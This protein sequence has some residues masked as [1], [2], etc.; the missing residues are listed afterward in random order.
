M[1]TPN[2]QNSN[3]RSNVRTARSHRQS[4]AMRRLTAAL[5]TIA[6]AVAATGAAYTATAALDGIRATIVAA[7]PLADKP[8][9]SAANG[10]SYFAEQYSSYFLAAGLRHGNVNFS[11]ASMW[12]ALAIAAQGA[13]GETRAQLDRVLQTQSL[14][15]GDYR[16]LISSINGRREGAAS[17]MLARNAVWADDTLTLS[18][19]FASTVR[20]AFD[21]NVVSLP[22]GDDATQRLREWIKEGTRGELAPDVRLDDGRLLS[23]VNTVYA[24]GRWAEPFDAN[25][26]KNGTFHGSNSDATVP[27]M[28]R[29][30]ENTTW[31]FSKK[32][33]WQTATLTFDDGG[34]FTL[35]LPDEGQFDEI[36][37]AG[38]SLASRAFR[39][40]TSDAPDGNAIWPDETERQGPIPD[41]LGFDTTAYAAQVTVTMPRFSIT[42]TFASDELIGVLRK[43]GVTDAFDPERADFA[44]MLDA[45]HSAVKDAALYVDSVVQGTRIDVNERGAKAAAYTDIGMATSAA[46]ASQRHVDFTVDR[47]FLYQYA[48]PDG[49]PLFVGAVTDL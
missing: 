47:P 3:V 24:D 37:Q 30:F 8:S 6:F 16:S 20:D 12:L 35:L 17:E 5:L 15:A 10:A 9:T 32:E 28:T 49:I 23:I 44:K 40:G 21:A 42:N 11:P 2:T 7:R 19:E 38:S 46:P 4:A 34:T 48:T 45:D 29:T 39:A 27:M 33:G 1:T 43:I 13:D 36:A 26:T 14:T 18:D 25:D 41:V 22:F 31:A